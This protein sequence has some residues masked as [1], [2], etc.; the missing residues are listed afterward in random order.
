[1]AMC[2]GYQKPKK[3]KAF[4]VFYVREAAMGVRLR[5]SLDVQGLGPKIAAAVFLCVFG[6]LTPG[7]QPPG[8]WSYWLY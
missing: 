8:W 4:R 1:M 6:L 2:N 3:R 5:V 7:R